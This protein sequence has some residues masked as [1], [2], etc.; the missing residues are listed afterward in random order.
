MTCKQFHVRFCI[1]YLF[2]GF[3]FYCL[4]NRPSTKRRNGRMHVDSA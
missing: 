4:V 2:Y 3:G 1:T